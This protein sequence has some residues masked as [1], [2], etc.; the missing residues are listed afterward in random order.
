MIM[1][2]RELIEQQSKIIASLTRTIEVLS[3]ENSEKGRDCKELLTRLMDAEDCIVRLKRDIE[4]MRELHRKE[5]QSMQHSA[6]QVG[7]TTERNRILQIVKDTVPSLINVGVKVAD[8]ELDYT[9]ACQIST[10]LVQGKITEGRNIEGEEDD[11][12]ED[13]DEEDS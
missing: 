7:E 13:E 3:M 4:K 12:S 1:E 9:E 8:E 2:A 5:M 10:S 6:T 11:Y